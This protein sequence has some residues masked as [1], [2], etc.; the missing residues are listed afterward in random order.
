MLARAMASFTFLLLASAALD[1]HADRI[2]CESRDY[3]RNYCPA[4]QRVTGASLVEQQSRSA[5][6]Q[7]RTW[8][9]DSGGIWVTQGCARVRIRSTV[10]PMR[11]NLPS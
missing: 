3:H 11:F 7:G 5:F 9:F 2:Y 10:T 6:I 1:A 8:G 4:G